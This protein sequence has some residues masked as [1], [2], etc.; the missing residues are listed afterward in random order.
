MRAA[1]AL[2]VAVALLGTLASAPTLASAEW[3]VDFYAGA[4]STA[5]ADVSAS[6]R[7]CSGFFCSPASTAS[8]EVQFDSSF[9]VGGRV[10]HWFEP[11][12]WLGVAFDVSYFQ[13]N[14]EDVEITVVPLSLLLML[15]W[16]LLATPDF[17]RGRLQPYIG[18]GPG[19]FITDVSVDFR[20]T[21]PNALSITDVEA[22]FDARAGLAWQFH[23]RFAVFG[24]YRFTYVDAEVTEGP[25]ELFGSGSESR[26]QTTLETHHFLVGVSVRF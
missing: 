18:I 2:L 8:R 15:R 23:R 10:G 4:A 26:V 7:F 1:T 3:F 6:D 11:I 25:P 24:E 16:P 5:D 17:P 21:L 20:P 13:A 22:G 12:P 14:G 19:A 9:T